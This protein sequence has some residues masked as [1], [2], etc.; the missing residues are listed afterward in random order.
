LRNLIF[1]LTF[2]LTVPSSQVLYANMAA[3]ENMMTPT[4]E[5]DE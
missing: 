1:D 2:T 4:A 3:M 5:N